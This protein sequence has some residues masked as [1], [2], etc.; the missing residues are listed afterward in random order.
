M[1]KQPG[2]SRVSDIKK[3]IVCKVDGVNIIGNVL[4]TQETSWT[5]RE[6]VRIY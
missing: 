6:V 5:K 3:V 2:L 4:A 1:R